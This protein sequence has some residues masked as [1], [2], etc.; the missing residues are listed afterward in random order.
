M[1]L[2]IAVIGCGWIS[3]SSH[4]PAYLEYAHTHPAA[5][6]LAACCDNQ[7]ERA[8]DFRDRFGFLRAYS[9]PFQM[10][11]RERPDIVCLNVPPDR[12][13]ELGCAVLRRGHA[14]LSEKPP[15]LSVAE[16]DRLIAAARESG[17]LHMVA[18]NRRFMPLAVELKARLAAGPTPEH[19]VIQMA[20]IGRTDA[21]FATTAVHAI[22]LAR[23]LAGS[24]F[25]ELRFQYQE[26]PELGS[27]VANF[28][29]DGRFASGVTAQLSFQPIS[30]TNIERSAVYARGHAFFLE[31]NNGPDAPGRLRH[32]LQGQ[33]VADLDAAQFCG[34]SDDCFLNGFYQEDA[35]FFDAVQAGVQPVHTFQSCRQSIEIMACLTER[36][37]S[38]P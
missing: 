4:G 21:N 31:A 12:L 8:L 3:H 6:L 34:R 10:L 33:L 30:G 37:A 27:G 18:F 26:L 36:R 11:E 25:Q 28:T 35:A 13:S 38:Y 17:A 7:L 2:S 20:R 1:P 16:V 15:G 24:D 19:L 5:L 22:D 23:F 32:Y 29:L 9:D 14:L